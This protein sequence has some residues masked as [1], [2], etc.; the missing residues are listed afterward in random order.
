MTMIVS[1]KFLIRIRCPI[2][3]DHLLA[4][5]SKRRAI[6]CQ[7]HYRNYLTWRTFSFFFS[8]L[9][10][11][12]GATNNCNDKNESKVWIIFHALC[13]SC[14]LYFMFF[15]VRNIFEINIV[16]TQVVMIIITITIVNI[17]V[18]IHLKRLLIMYAPARAHTSYLSFFYTGKIFVE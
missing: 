6:V 7:C 9:I 12:A 14:S 16:Q 13:I 5:G 2:S 8:R 3:R 18:E 15:G 10:W 1:K 4:G 11:Y 17:I